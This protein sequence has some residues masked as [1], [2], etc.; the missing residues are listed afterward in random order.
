MHLNNLLHLFSKISKTNKAHACMMIAG[1]M[2]VIPTISTAATQQQIDAASKEADRIQREQVDRLEQERREELLKRPHTTIEVE[3]P[4]DVT[5]TDEGVCRDV[6]EIII[7]GATLMPESTRQKLV[8]PYI[9]KCMAVHDIELLLSDITKYYMD[10]GFIAARAYIQP[11]DLATGILRVLVVEGVVEKLILDGDKTNSSV[12]LPSAFPFLAGEPLNLRDIE[13]GLD[14]VNRLASNNATM[15]IKPGE[16]AGGTI[17]LIHNQPLR[18]LR[19]NLTYDNFGGT[20]T[21]EEQLGLNVSLDNPMGLNDSLNV[22]HR[23]STDSDFT[24]IHSRS[25]SFLYSV[26]IGYLTLTASHTWSDY[27]TTIHPPGGDLISNGYSKNTSL[28]SEYVAYRDKTNRLA[29]TGTLT[30]KSSENYLAGQLLGVSSRKLSTFDLG[31]SWNT[32][33]FDGVLGLNLGHVWGL[34]MFSALQDPTGLPDI[35]PH[36]QFRKWVAGANWM[37]P[38]QIGKQNF[39]FSTAINAQAGVDVLY[40]SEQFSIGSLYSVRGYRNTSIAGD[41][42]YYWRNDLA[43]PFQVQAGG[44]PFNIKPYIGYDIGSVRDRN[45]EIGGHLTGMVVGVTASTARVSADIS[46]VKPL[47]MPD[48]LKDEGFQLFAKLTVNF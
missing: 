7:E 9:G 8:A 22:T 24:G 19:A 38:F 23:R 43:V 36:A 35:A 46:G 44:M 18:R 47:S 34:R 33:L 48:A 14:Q 13:Q 4:S 27:A 40:G 26:P 41:T 11:Q 42:G 29:V 15:E 31:T 1:L 10:K 20:A 32:R 6:K 2:M 5:K 45:A 30:A 3:T 28:S 16:K 21:G 39:T 37:R 12:F 25:N 17:V